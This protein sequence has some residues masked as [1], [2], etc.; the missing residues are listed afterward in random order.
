MELANPEDLN[1]EDSIADEGGN[2][3]TT[4]EN[5]FFLQNENIRLL[6]SQIRYGAGSPEGVISA[7][8]GTLYL[9]SLG[10]AGTTLYVKETGTGNT[11]Q[12]A[13]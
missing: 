12:S 7:N 5:Q 4:F 3:S 1:L 9:N 11:G 8:M 10:G 2:A 13:K 6:R